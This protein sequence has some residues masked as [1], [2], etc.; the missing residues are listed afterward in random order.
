MCK[1]YNTIGSLKALKQQ[2]E[3]QNIH[4]FKSLNAVI[5]FQ[6]SY[7]AIRKQLIVDHKKQLEQEKDSLE[8]AIK[9]LATSIET[10]R[11]Y[12]KDILT[13]EIEQLKAQL[14]ELTS[15]IPAH[16]F[17]RGILFVKVWRLKTKIH[18]KERFFDKAIQESIAFLTDEYQI[19]SSRYHYLKN[20]I[21]AAV[22]KT[23]QIPLSE[24]DRKKQTIDSLNTYI[25]GALG[26]HKVVKALAALPDDYI[27]INDFSV[28]F[29]PAIYNRK[30]NDYIKSAQIDHILIAPSGIFLIE[31]KNWSKNSV[32]DAYLRSPVRQI[33]RSS[34]VLFMLLNN[35]MNAN[36]LHLVKHHWGNKKISIKNLIVLTNTK[37][38]EAFQ[39]VKV[40][41]VDELVRYVTH[42]EP[43]HSPTETQHI[44]EYLL[45]INEKTIHAK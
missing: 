23:V 26:E 44:A 41:T 24:L 3:R 39:Y 12:S 42:F 25:Y 7:T 9:H 17:Q 33:K 1:T 2:L 36:Y 30:E 14:Y 28:T 22:D 38:K 18:K 19:K 4:N 21:D 11:T 37:P 20:H 45:R 13:A 6:R 34:Y 43:I 15:K 10:Q 32:N 40:L 8:T 27:L 29:S 5:D 35:E 31:T 16:F